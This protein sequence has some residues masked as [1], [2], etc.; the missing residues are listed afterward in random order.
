VPFEH[1]ARAL[2]SCGYVSMPENQRENWLAERLRARAHG[3]GARIYEAT[4][5]S[6]IEV[7]EYATRDG[8]RAVIR[9]DVS[10][11]KRVEEALRRS[12]A[13]LAAAQR[14]AGLGSWEMTFPP[15]R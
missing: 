8:G 6:W 7:R 1:L 13:R 5:G 15:I 14:L 4:D 9:V 11:Q 10:Q 12:E 2:V 3:P